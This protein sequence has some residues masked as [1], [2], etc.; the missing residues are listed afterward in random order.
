MTHK[1]AGLDPAIIHS[2]FN[3]QGEAPHRQLLAWQHRVGHIVDV[4][5]SLT[6]ATL[7]FSGHIDRYTIGDLVFTDSRTDS[8]RL[9]RSVARILTDNTRCYVFQVFMEGGLG[10]VA[11][12][13]R[14]RDAA[15]SGVGILALDLNQPFRIQR[16][17]C[18]V[19]TFFVPRLLVESIYPDADALHG[20]FVADTSPLTRMVCDH[21]A[22]LNQNL[23]MLSASEVNSALRDGVHLLVAA[24]CK[25]AGLTG[26]ARAVARA[27]LFG[28][29]RRYI[30]AHIHQAVLSPESVLTALQLPRPTL[31]RM[32][33][34]EGG[35][36]AY[37]RNLRLREAAD[38]L[39]KF[40][41]MAVM[42]I[43]YGLGFKSAS[44]FTRAFR[45][46]YDMAPQHLRALV[47]GSQRAQADA[48]AVAPPASR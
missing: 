4:L 42:D 12:L 15:Q 39:V 29:V 34:H 2:H 40:P 21:M 5:P 30:R 28:Q 38:E 23:A 36:G 31:Y 9:E 47:F 37:I 43:A 7:G 14:Q 20:R 18:R 32:F 33:E 13:Y 19:L 41:H 8:L 48:P 26:N 35:I 46:A 17:A 24:F 16:A 11:G 44:D 6:P 3:T 45:R 10:T 25:Q 1:H 22:A 27:S